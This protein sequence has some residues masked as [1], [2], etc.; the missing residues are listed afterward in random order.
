MGFYALE[1]DDTE[2][3][4]AH[5]WLT[6]SFIGQGIGRRMFDHA[7]QTA[8]GLGAREL[9]IEADPNAEGFYLH[10]GADRVGESVSLLT[11]TERVIPSLRYKIIQAGA[12]TG[13]QRESVHI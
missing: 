11:G 7:A 10:L 1:I 12:V 4:L 5:F 8:F 6:P 3:R 9:R 2:F 13:A